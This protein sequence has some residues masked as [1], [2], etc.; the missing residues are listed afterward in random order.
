[1]DYEFTKDRT[2]GA[3]MPTLWHILGM[4]MMGLIGV[5]GVLGLIML[6]LLEVRLIVR[7]AGRISSAA[8]LPLP[9]EYF[10][11]APTQREL[12]DYWRN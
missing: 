12:G 6:V 11:D 9:R 4:T 2:E 1:V 7:I 10:P 3:T 5:A 8:E